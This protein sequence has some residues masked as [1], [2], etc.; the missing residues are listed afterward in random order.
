[1]NFF[2]RL[3]E[4]TWLGEVV[5]DYGVISE[6]RRGIGRTKVSVL[7]CKNEGKLYLVIKVSAFAVI[8]GSV[9]YTYVPSDA[10]GTFRD[11]VNDAYHRALDDR[12]T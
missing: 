5:H 10:L 9:N 8:A 12:V 4:K 2:R 7:L 1:M 6:V 3:E 11:A